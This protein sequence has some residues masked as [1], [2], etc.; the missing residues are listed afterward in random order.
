MTADPN[1]D[2]LTITG[3][4]NGVHGAASF[5][6]QTNTAT[7]TPANGYT[8]PASFTY[9]ISDGRG[10]IASARPLSP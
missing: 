4:S 8:G 6:A 9:A 5:S 2:P 10:G 7:F 3:V 1:G